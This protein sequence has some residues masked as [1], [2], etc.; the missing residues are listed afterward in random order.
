MHSPTI[1][2]PF[3]RPTVAKSTPISKTVVQKRGTVT[4]AP[5]SSKSKQRRASVAVLSSR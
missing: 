1:I 4:E 3:V 2:K 5:D